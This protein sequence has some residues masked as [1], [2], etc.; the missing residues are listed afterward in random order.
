MAIDVPVYTTRETIKRAL[1]QGEVARNNVNIDR[2][3]E[4][5][6]R[7]AETLCHRHAFYP[8]VDT[9]KFDWPNEQDALSWRLWLDDHL[10]ISVTSMTSGGDAISTSSIFLEPNRSGPPFN[11]LQISTASSAAFGIGSTHQQ[12]ISITGLWGWNDD[13]TTAGV[14][15]EALDASETGVDVDAAASARVGVGSILKIGTERL[16]VTERVQLDTGVNV[17]GAGLTNG[18][19]DTALTVA[20]GT[21]F[22]VGEVLLIDS[23]RVLVTDIAGNTLVIERAFDGTNSA[24][25]TT[26][27]DIYAP[28][29]LTVTRGALGSTAATHDN[30]ATVSVW[31]VPP[32]LRQLVTSEA[33]HELM[34]EQTGWFRTM[35]ASSIFGGTAKRAATIDAIVDYREQA[36][37]THGRKAR[38][39][40]V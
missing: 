9:R 3:I 4:T 1:D 7:N 37:R 5:A 39:R 30:G 24:A 21:V 32:A 36:Y 33:I 12:D 8:Q 40:T 35:S 2:C 14:T 16:L 15:V 26:S 13:H 34:Q 6:S 38:S 23:E 31:T 11:Q 29:T 10:L 25:H 19:G 28:R 27:S 20:D 17:G 22:A 18:K